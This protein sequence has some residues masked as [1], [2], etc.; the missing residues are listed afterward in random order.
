MTDSVCTGKKNDGR[1]C[2][3]IVQSG[4]LFCRAHRSQIEDI[5]NL[6]CPKGCG[7]LSYASFGG[8]GSLQTEI[9]YYQCKKCKGSLLNAKNIGSILRDDSDKVKTLVKL[10][11]RGVPS[12]IDCPICECQMLKMRVRYEIPSSGVPGS[13]A[14]GFAT[15]GGVAGLLIGLTIAAASESES[16]EKSIRSLVLDG[17][18]T[19][20]SFW[21]DKGEVKSIRNNPLTDKKPKRKS[22]PEQENREY[23]GYP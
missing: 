17:C 10:L 20:S 12:D 3:R 7:Q 2:G 11:E 23:R 21:F 4:Q 1:P 16:K 5:E 8:L 15:G 9:G 6:Q 18:K 19:C 13:V 14:S 22:E